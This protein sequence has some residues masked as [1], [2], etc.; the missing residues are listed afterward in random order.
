MTVGGE[1]Y[2]WGGNFF[3]Q[4]G[5]GTQ[6][7]REAPGAPSGALAIASI[8]AGYLHT[9][10]LTPEGEAQCWG[11]NGYGEVGDS[12]YARRYEPTPVKG[13]LRFSSIFPGGGSCHGHTCGITTDG[14]VYC[15]GKKYQLWDNGFSGPFYPVPVELQGNPGFAE[16]TVGGYSVCGLTNQGKLFCWG[17]GSYRGGV[18]NGQVTDQNDPTPIRPDLSFS[19]ATG[20]RYHTCA[21]TP[22][23][24]TYCWGLNTNGQLGNH[25]NRY[26]WTVPMA[27][28]G[29]PEG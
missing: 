16:I 2:C 1:A 21:V 20:G 6:E 24:E 17:D 23:G 19:T 12:T 27:V 15:W 26:G 5:D 18:G 29:V 8:E 11:Y 7:D 10:A 22:E 25:A 3:G 28:W 9:C 4:L 14:A 13:G